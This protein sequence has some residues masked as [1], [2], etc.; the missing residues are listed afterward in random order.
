MV[1]VDAPAAVV[2]FAPFVSAVPDT[3]L[4]CPSHWQKNIAQR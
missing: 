3:T 2:A 1:V 4:A